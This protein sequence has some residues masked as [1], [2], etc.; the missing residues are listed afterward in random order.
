MQK[1][2][3]ESLARV[4]NDFKG[5]IQNNIANVTGGGGGGNSGYTES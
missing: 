1:L 2:S 4:V 5:T 3:E